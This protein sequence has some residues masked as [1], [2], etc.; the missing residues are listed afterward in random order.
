MTYWKD[1][2][3]I[4]VSQ[5]DTQHR[6]L[7][8]AV[9]ELMEACS[10]GQG[11]ATIEKTLNFVVSYTKEHFADEERLQAQHGYLGIA[12]HKKL[13]ADF[14]TSVSAL[15]ADFQKSGSGLAL[16]ANVNKTLVAWLTHHISVEDKKVGEFIKSKKT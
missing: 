4:G 9:D 13:H 16:T 8:Q 3:L 5:I 12:A 6:K 1:S 11:R 7:V 2:L 15:V 10:K 14:I